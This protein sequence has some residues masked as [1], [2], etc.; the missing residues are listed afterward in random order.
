MKVKHLNNGQVRVIS[1]D[2]EAIYELLRETM[3]ENREEYFDILGNTV[4]FE[5]KWNS[6]TDIFTCAVFDRR[7]PPNDLDF[8]KLEEHLGLTTKTLY[9]K[10]RYK[11]VYIKDMQ[12]KNE[13]L[14]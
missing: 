3:M 8:D 6:K 13:E 11:T 12:V 10:K 1:I 4:M 7:Y 14:T 5:M 2:R 9:Q